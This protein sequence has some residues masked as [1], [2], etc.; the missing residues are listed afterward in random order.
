MP[1]NFGCFFFVGAATDPFPASRK[2]E[3]MQ[4]STPQSA[5]PLLQG[6]S[7]P[8]Q[9]ASTP[10]GGASILVQGANTTPP[11]TSTPLLLVA[12]FPIIA[13]LTTTRSPSLLTAKSRKRERLENFF[14]GK[15]C[16]AYGFLLSSME[17][18]RAQT[19]W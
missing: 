9:D 17:A 4:D 6:T 10:P 3:E 18:C 15:A 7:T 2:C 11:G 14:K 12:S 1:R 13:Q 19:H 5:I 8:L 16:A